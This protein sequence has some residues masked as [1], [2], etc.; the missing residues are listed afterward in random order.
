MGGTV[1]FEIERQAQT[2]LAS[3][4]RGGRA[5]LLCQPTHQKLEL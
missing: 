5:G 4:F 2:A 3:L 1:Y